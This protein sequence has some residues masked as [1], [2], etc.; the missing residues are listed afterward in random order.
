MIAHL[1]LQKTTGVKIL[2]YHKSL[3][4]MAPKTIFF[5]LIQILKGLYFFVEFVKLIFKF[6]VNIQY[7][8]TL[9]LDISDSIQTSYCTFLGI[10][11]CFLC[12]SC[13]IK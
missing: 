10:L 9:H 5:L 11:V 6:Y 8:T 4:V 13:K 1:S 7:F 2:T 3:I 12:F